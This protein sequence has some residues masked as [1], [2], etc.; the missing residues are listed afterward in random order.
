[1]HTH[2]TFYLIHVLLTHSPTPMHTHNTQR[3]CKINMTHRVSTEPDVGMPQAEAQ[4][5]F[6]QLIDGLVGPLC[7]FVL[8]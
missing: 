2:N 8:I 1:M 7:H 6:R 4:K 5:Y 3:I